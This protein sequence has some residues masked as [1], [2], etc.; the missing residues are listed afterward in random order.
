MRS[1]GKSLLHLGGVAIAHRR[2][3]VVGRLRPHHRR[4]RLCGLDRVDHRG[5]HLVIDHDR[6]G[7]VLRQHARARD[8]GRDRLAGKAHHLVREQTARRHRHRLAVLS[9][10]D[11]KRRDGADIVGDQ[12]CAGIDRLD[13]RHL[14]GCLGINRN[15]FGVGMGRAQHM[16]PQRALLRPVVDELSLPGEQSL[17]FQTLDWLAR[18]KTQITGKNVHQ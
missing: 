11:R 5:Q 16:Q 12:V 4:A 2:D 18:T 14:A 3:D 17:I 7:R 9:L 15:D 10:E 8:H 13:T 6:L 1:A